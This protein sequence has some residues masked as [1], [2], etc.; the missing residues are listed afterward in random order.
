M[1]SLQEML[2]TLA[3]HGDQGPIDGICII[4]Q[5]VEVKPNSLWLHQFGQGRL[6]LRGQLSLFSPF[7]Q[8]LQR[9]LMALLR[10]Y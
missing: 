2:W 8:G 7:V 10:E 4:G 1:Q 9:S 3:E 6:I 5:E